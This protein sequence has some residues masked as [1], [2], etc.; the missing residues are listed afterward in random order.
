MLNINSASNNCPY[1]LSVGMPVTLA[2]TPVPTPVM[3]L[4]L[5][6]MAICVLLLSVFDSF[7]T[8][9]TATEMT[10]PG[11]TRLGVAENGMVTLPPFG[12]PPGA[13]TASSQI[14]NVSL[15]RMHSFGTEGSRT[16]LAGSVM[17]TV[18]LMLVKPP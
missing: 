10:A 6:L 8:P 9:D 18:P 16:R 7:A 4:P 15:S 2:P 17:A 11:A 12:N 14:I 5:A 1:S 13:S 3:A